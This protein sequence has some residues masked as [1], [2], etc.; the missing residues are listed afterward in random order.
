MPQFVNQCDPRG[1]RRASAT[2]AKDLNAMRRMAEEHDR[3]E[4]A[5]LASLEPTVQNPPT[6]NGEHQ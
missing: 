3:R 5:R 6:K 1:F 2:R 4:R